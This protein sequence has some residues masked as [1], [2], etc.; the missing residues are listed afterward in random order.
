MED[1]NDRIFSTH[2]MALP[3]HRFDRASSLTPLGRA[4]PAKPFTRTGRKDESHANLHRATNPFRRP[5][6]EVEVAKIGGRS[7]SCVE[8]LGTQI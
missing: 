3:Q 7:K 8:W 1:D 6:C 5:L 2:W 4:F